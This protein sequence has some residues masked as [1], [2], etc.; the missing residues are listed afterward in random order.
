MR[1]FPLTSNL[2][3][4][5]PHV[6]KTE[7]YLKQS[8]R[9]HRPGIFGFVIALQAE[10]VKDSSSMKRH[11]QE[12][13]AEGLHHPIFTIPYDLVVMLKGNK[14]EVNTQHLQS[15]CDTKNQKDSLNN[16]KPMD[17]PNQTH[18]FWS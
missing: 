14:V 15:R 10:A 9:P 1:Q 3:K 16:T 11:E 7:M 12:I 5:R 2:S 18:T 4:A 6:D 17:E 13:R 8:N